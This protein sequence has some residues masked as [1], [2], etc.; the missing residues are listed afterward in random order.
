LVVPKRTIVLVVSDFDEGFPVG[1]LLS[2]VRELVETGAIGLGLAAL[3]DTGKPRY[4]RAIA[5]MVVAAGMAVA[6]L[7]PL[8]LAR[9]IGERIRG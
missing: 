5:E 7:T 4:N 6:A 8:E 1:A 2:E 9:W 3:S